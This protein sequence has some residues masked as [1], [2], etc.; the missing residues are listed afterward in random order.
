[1]FVHILIGLFDKTHALIVTVELIWLLLLNILSF[2]F[3][4]TPNKFLLDWQDSE[5]IK[6]QNYI[7]CPVVALINH[8]SYT[9]FLFD[10]RYAV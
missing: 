6:I 10:V 1:M 8:T 7:K 9:A 2:N 5:D 3:A 4:P